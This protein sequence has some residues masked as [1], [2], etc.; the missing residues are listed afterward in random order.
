MDAIQKLVAIEAI[1][2]LKA[3]YH[4]AVDTKDWNLLASVLT[5]DARSVYSDGLFSFAGRDEIL[6]FHK[7][8][9]ETNDIVTMHQSHMPEIEITSETTARG[10]WYLEDTV[11]NAGDANEYNPGR[12]VLIGTGIYHDEYAKVDGEWLISVTGY[13]RIFEYREPMHA[14]SSLKTRWNSRTPA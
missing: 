4:R 13:K 10:S 8:A 2:Q 14:E 6:E 9:L 12:S 1:K 3:R 11:I 7:G 5:E